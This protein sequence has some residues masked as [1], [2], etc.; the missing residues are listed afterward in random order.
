LPPA[1]FIFWRDAFQKSTAGLLACCSIF[2]YNFFMVRTQFVEVAEELTAV[3]NNALE[4]RDRFYLGVI[5]GHKREPSKAQKKL[6][7]RSSVLGSP[8]V[9]RGS[10]FK[11]LS[12]LWKGLTSGQK[13]AWKDAAV[14][15]SLT[16]WQLFISDN[17]ARI[18]N[19]IS[20]PVS[21]SELWQVNSGYITLVSPASNI[22]LKQ[23]HPL[24]Y[25][26]L[27]KIPGRSWKK[28]LVLLR[29]IFSLP[30]TIKIRYKSNLTTE[31]SGQIARYKITVWTSYQGQDIYTDFS[32]NFSPSVDWTLATVSTSGLFGII[33]GYTLFIEIV[34]YRGELLFDNLEANHSGSNWARD[35]R[36]DDVSKTFVKAFSV[37]PPFWVPVSLPSGSSFS[38]IFPPVL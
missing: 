25:W 5:Q 1:F 3:Y 22:T 14:F 34:G 8:Q 27:E 13:T 33:I 19:S 29:E 2:G 36:C 38:S 28:Q 37:V 4:R 26:T 32:I 21:P 10:L 6:L 12:P 30:L 11:Y 9:G 20:F 7:K 35:P 23:E 24:D 16:G 15:S 18:R 17:A 31:G